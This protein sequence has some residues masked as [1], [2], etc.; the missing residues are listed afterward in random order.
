M[1]CAVMDCAVMDCAV[2]VAV[3][4]GAGP[5]GRILGMP[6]G[7]SAKAP[8]PAVEGWFT[9]D[10]ERPRLLGGRCGTCGTYSFPR[11]TIC[12]PNPDCEAM[13]PEQVP[14]SR[15]GRLWSFTDNR[16]RPPEPYLSPEPFEAYAIAAV[17]LADEKMVV[18]GQLVAGVDVSSLEAGG[19]V[20][21]VLDTLFEDDDHSY[22][23]WKWKPTET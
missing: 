22:K 13:E 23:V 1:D 7:P 21:L 17:E 8:L 19:P 5:R 2:G 12:C 9:M 4:K 6:D 18:L 11:A 16:Y 10:E 3:V 20:E 14:L 15:T